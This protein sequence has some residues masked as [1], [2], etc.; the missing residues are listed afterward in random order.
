[1]T[2][3][4]TVVSRSGRR[5]STMSHNPDQAPPAPPQANAVLV[6]AEPAKQPATYPESPLSAGKKVRLWFF[7]EPFWRVRA[8]QKL[9]DLQAIAGDAR[10]ADIARDVEVVRTALAAPRGPVSWLNGAHIERAWRALH[11]I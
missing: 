5:G 8:R 1:M 3:V 10:A 2:R 7:P 11:A 9:L 4:P 6:V